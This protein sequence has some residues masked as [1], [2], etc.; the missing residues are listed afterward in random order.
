MPN[1]YKLDASY[2]LKLDTGFWEIYAVVLDKW[3]GV[4]KDEILNKSFYKLDFI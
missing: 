3:L 2:N 4:N 1:F